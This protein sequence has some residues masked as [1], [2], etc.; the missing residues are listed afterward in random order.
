[1]SHAAPLKA[2][3]QQSLSL[4]Q[5]LVLYAQQVLATTERIRALPSHSKGLV[6]DEEERHADRRSH[7]QAGNLEAHKQMKKLLS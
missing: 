3:S 5:V 7:G 1:V 2:P 4:Q 6:K